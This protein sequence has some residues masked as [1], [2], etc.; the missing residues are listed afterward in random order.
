MSNQR[1][2]IHDYAIYKDFKVVVV[3][4]VS[5]D[6]KWFYEVRPLECCNNISKLIPQEELYACKE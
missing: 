3:K 5:Q 2:F 6:N 1:F 4:V